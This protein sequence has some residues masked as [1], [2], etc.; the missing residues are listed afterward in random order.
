M[1]Q[2]AT[3]N[4]KL[5]KLFKIYKQERLLAKSTIKNYNALLSIFVK[6]T[7]CKDTSISHENIIKWRDLV[8]SRATNSTY[9]TYLRQLKALFNFA[10]ENNIISCN[11]F[12]KIQ[13]IPV[14][15]TYKKT[16]STEDLQSIFNEL[17]NNNN[18][19]YWFWKVAV[20]TLYYTAMRRKQIVTLCWDDVNWDKQ[21]FKMSVKGSKTKREYYIPFNHKIHNGLVLL[22]NKTMEINKICPIDQVFNI[23]IFNKKYKKNKMTCN[24]ISDFLRY[25]SRKLNIKIST[26]RFR[27]TAAT[28]AAN[29]KDVNIKT[30]QNF[31]GHTNITTTLGY[32]HPSIDDI[33]KL[34]NKL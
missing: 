4:I 30:V 31:L 21:I 6:D 27:H 28:K 34:Q 16:I 13:T 24:H 29:I 8:L 3:Q 5:N 9:N 22:R 14:Y 1:K 11:Q 7:K 25:L 32:I 2:K 23:T 26:H 19:N 12:K 20:D 10:L 15:K 33:K 17:D 18:Y